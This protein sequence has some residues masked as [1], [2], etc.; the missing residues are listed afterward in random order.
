LLEKIGRKTMKKLLIV[1][2]A[3]VLLG[4]WAS[5]AQATL[6]T[7]CISPGGDLKNVAEG[8]E[9]SKPCGRNDT[10]TQ[11]EEPEPDPEPEALCPCDLLSTA[12]WAGW[13]GPS[14][15]IAVS[16]ITLTVLS[17]DDGFVPSVQFRLFNDE[18]FRCSTVT[19]NGDG[20]IR[21]LSTISDEELAACYADLNQLAITLGL[22]D[23]CMP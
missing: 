17:L 11:W 9:P 2:T 23:G 6:F 22:R 3:F 12:A 10:L 20:F 8:P 14:C 15:S 1:I 4:I 7:G 21:D 18:S 19:D 13:A 16:G 5:S